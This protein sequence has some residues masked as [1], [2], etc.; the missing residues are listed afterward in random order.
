M[1]AAKP[2]ASSPASPDGSAAASTA[3]GT[4]PSAAASANTSTEPPAPARDTVY[5]GVDGDPG[6]LDPFSVSGAGFLTVMHCYSEPLWAYESADNIK[7][8][9][10][11]SVDFVSDTEWLIHLRK[12]VKFS[13]G[14]PFTA[15]TFIFTFN[16]VV[17]I[18]KAFLLASVDFEKTVAEDDYTIRLILTKARYDSVPDHVRYR[19]A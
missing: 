14:S 15:P 6:T 12:D 7:Y 19:D 10:A 9:L 11:E 1:P 17:E 16:H 4:T 8:L 18:K 2:P 5:V 13:N 3:P